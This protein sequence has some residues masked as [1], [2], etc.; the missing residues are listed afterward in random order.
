MQ[1][2]WSKSKQMQTRAAMFSEQTKDPFRLE[3]LSLQASI[4]VRDRKSGSRPHKPSKF[5]FVAEQARGQKKTYTELYEARFKQSSAS[6]P[7]ENQTRLCIEQNNTAMD[8][9]FNQC[10][11][12]SPLVSTID[13]AVHGEMKHST[14]II[15]TTLVCI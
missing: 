10:L 15:L 13:D 3:P 12:D 4:H 2:K 1:L 5:R 8:R 6:Y 7:G 9:S 11:S 14:F